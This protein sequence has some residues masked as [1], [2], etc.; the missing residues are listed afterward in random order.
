MIILECIH[1]IACASQSS[2]IV[3]RGRV[4][5]AYNVDWLVHMSDDREQKRVGRCLLL[6][7]LFD[8][9]CSRRTDNTGPVRLVV[10]YDVDSVF[11]IRTYSRTLTCGLLR[12]TG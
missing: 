8:V 2:S 4:D 11:V 1:R 12:A 3:P 6:S 7:L 9:G 5:G 10:L